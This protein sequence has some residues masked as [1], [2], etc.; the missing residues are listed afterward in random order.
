M[1]YLKLEWD[2]NI[3][4]NTS[5]WSTLWHVLYIPIA[6]VLNSHQISWLLSQSGYHPI[7]F[8][9][10]QLLSIIKRLNH[11]FQDQ[12]SQTRYNL[13]LSSH[14]GRLQHHLVFH[15]YLSLSS[16]VLQTPPSSASI[17]RISSSFDVIHTKI[18][19][20]VGNEKTAKLS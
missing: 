3:S 8:N 19:N 11:Y 18:R 9:I 12:S 2:W 16:L 10:W 1:L 6:R 4:T 20:R 17:E 5:Q 7:V 13:Y 15:H 14:V